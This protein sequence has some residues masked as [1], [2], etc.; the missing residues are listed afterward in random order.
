[1]PEQIGQIKQLK[2][3]LKQ[4]QSMIR[5]PVYS[6]ENGIPQIS[7]YV[8]DEDGAFRRTQ[9]EPLRL[10]RDDIQGISISQGDMVSSSYDRYERH[11]RTP[12]ITFHYGRP[13]S[14]YQFLRDKVARNRFYVFAKPQL[15]GHISKFSLHELQLKN[16]ASQRK[17]AILK[18]KYV[19]ALQLW[20]EEEVAA[21]V[22][23]KTAASLSVKNVAEDKIMHSNR[24]QN[25]PVGE[26]SANGLEKPQDGVIHQPNNRV[27]QFRRADVQEHLVRE[28]QTASLVHSRSHTVP[29]K[30]EPRKNLVQ[31]FS[32]S[33][34]QQRPT[35]KQK[36]QNKHFI[37]RFIFTID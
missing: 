33:S 24:E 31:D 5:V 6:D 34:P 3:H 27:A 35:K 15:S 25:R 19:E 13:Q 22:S 14:Y 7:I 18:E 36:E 28:A 11:W 2:Q 1:M 26:I 29:S 10:L 32:L 8:E 21:Q 12:T 23:A 16:S 4:H 17:V 20:A 37:D 9:S 30:V